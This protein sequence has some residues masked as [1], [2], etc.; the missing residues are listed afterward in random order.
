MSFNSKSN[1]S[2]DD[3][4]GEDHF[5]ESFSNEAQSQAIQDFIESEGD[6]EIA[7]PNEAEVQRKTSHWDNV[8]TTEDTGMSS[9]WD[10]FKQ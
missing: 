3:L 7:L 2:L 6:T 4:H 5:E 9:K 8:D 1:I 10:K